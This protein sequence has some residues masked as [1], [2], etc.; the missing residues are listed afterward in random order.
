MS[1]T[2]ARILKAIAG[3]DQYGI[4]AGDLSKA[5]GVSRDELVYRG[6]EMESLRLI[7]ILNLTDLNFRLHE[8]FDYS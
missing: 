5:S 6:K 8:S 7:E 1:E 3:A 4:Y 2:N